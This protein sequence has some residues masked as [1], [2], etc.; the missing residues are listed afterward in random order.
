MKKWMVV[1]A[2]LSVAIG[3]YAQNLKSYMPADA[4]I[5]GSANG[6]AILESKFIRNLIFIS[7]QKTMEDILKEK[8][9]TMEQA[10]KRCGIAL[11]F[12]KATVANPAPQMEGGAIV[13]GSQKDS[14]KD[15]NTITQQ[16]LDAEL[17]KHTDILAPLQ[18]SGTKIELAKMV[19]K[20]AVLISMPNPAAI[21]I[22]LSGITDRM[23]QVRFAM[24]KAVEKTP[25]KPL[26][27]YSALTKMVDSKALLS[28]AIDVQAIAKLA[29]Q[30]QQDPVAAS[31][32]TFSASISEANNNLILQSDIETMSPDAANMIHAQLNAVFATMKNNPD[33]NAKAMADMIKLNLKGS[34]VELKGTFPVEFLINMLKKS[35]AN[36]PQLN[37]PA[38]TPANK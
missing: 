9:E 6:N 18:Q 30:L 26:K 36:V 10:K 23:F 28:V 2:A 34:N 29:P 7:T 3:A 1:F 27:Q 13:Y 25:L 21:Q 16:S 15:I 32:K 17:K 14:Y 20:N 37:A 8:G 33:A 5:V 19:D 24:D 38:A 4:M 22:V 11:F 31:I 35:L 12:L